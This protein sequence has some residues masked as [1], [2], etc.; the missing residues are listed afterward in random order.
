MAPE[1]RYVASRGNPSLAFRLVRTTAFRFTVIYVVVFAVAVGALG[2]LFY[3]ATFSA[4]ARQIDQIIDQD[5]DVLAAVFASDGPGT[6]RRLVRERSAWRD[7]GVYMLIGSPSGA[8]LA[9]NL[10]ALP[11]EALSAGEGFFDFSY[12]RPAIDAAGRETGVESRKGRG[13]IRVF[14][15][16]PDADTSFLVFVAR[17]IS[18]QE[19]LRQRSQAQMTRIGAATILLGLV[20]GIVFSRSLLRRVDAVN[21]TALARV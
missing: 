12:E 18:G 6:L 4:V 21:R 16:A 2:A 19:A 17:D 1:G 15:T 20:I 8:V 11:P 10:T 5:M 13:K 7:D 3:G 14:K 9:G